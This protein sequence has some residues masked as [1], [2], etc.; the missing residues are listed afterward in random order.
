M[1]L[2]CNTEMGIDPNDLHR[3]HFPKS[4]SWG[5]SV[6][7]AQIEGAWNQDGRG[8]SIWDHFASRKG[9]IFKGHHPKV[10]CNF[11]NCWEDDLQLV[12]NL[13][14]PAFR[15]SL[16]WSRILPEGI[17]RV[18]EKGLDFYKQL[19]DK[20]L[21][22]GI[23]PWAT[24][25]H[26]DLPQALEEK[27]GW[28]NRE[29]LHWFSEYAHLVGKSLGNRGVRN[30][31]VMNE[32]LV[33]TGAGYFLGYHAPGKRGLDSFL[34]A[35]VHAALA[36]AA[37]EKALRTGLNAGS[38]IGSTFSC[39]LMEP[40]RQTESDY[41]ATQ[42]VHALFNR[43]FVEASLGR[44]F[45]IETLPVLKEAEKWMKAGDEEAMKADLDFWGV[46]NY[47]RELIRAAWYV[48]YLKAR[49]VNAR[50]RNVPHTEMEWEVYP[51][52][53]LQMLRFFHGL[54]ADMPL[55]VTENGA[56]FHDPVQNG[57]VIDQQR[58]DFLKHYLA[59]VHQAV[60]EGIPLEGYFIWTLMDNFEWAEGYRPR[61]GLI[62]TDFETGERIPKQ[63]AFW[64]RDFLSC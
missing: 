55:V 57:Q 30:W 14:I 52:S 19:I 27:G 63:S 17:G 2:A 59:K 7:A 5:V 46:Q 44:G 39:S 23:E 43:L 16:S 28:R 24:L 34:P 56:A 6:A 58:I 42:K 29:I 25:Y 41:R 33:F 22:L 36:T 10:A 64:Y 9:K 38:R 12:R 35:M 60:E 15:F 47:T 40:F 32:P 31:M 18:N 11:Y 62:Y 20:Q 51:D 49:L 26:W 1:T 50:K 48:P 53:I 54:Q 21:E 4:F 8:P 45:P 13:Q 3:R 61:F 37:G